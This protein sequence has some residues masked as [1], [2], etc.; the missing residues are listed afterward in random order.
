MCMFTRGHLIT[1]KF[2]LGAA[3]RQGQG[4]WGQLPPFFPSDAIHG[5]ECFFVCNYFVSSIFCTL[6]PKKN[7]KKT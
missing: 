6:K 5:I 3:G 7:C 1:L 4:Y 2:F